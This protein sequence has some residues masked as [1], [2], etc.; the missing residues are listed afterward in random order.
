MRGRTERHLEQLIAG[1]P[2]GPATALA[3]GARALATAEEPQL[4]PEF[5]WRDYTIFLLSI[6]AQI[7]HSLMVQYLY[8]AYSLG[9]PQTPEDQ[10]EKVAAWR[11]VILGIAKE[12][13]GHLATVQNAL[14]LMDAPLELDRE[15][16][17]W[18]SRLAP[19]PFTLERLSRASLA[20]Y[21]VAESPK[22]WPPDV[23]AGERKEIEDL[24]SGYGGS[25]VNRVGELYSDLIKIIRNPKLLPGAVFHPDTYPLQAS[26]D[27][28]GRGYGK[29]ARGS[30]V[31]GTTATPD[32][33]VLRMASRTDAVAALQAVAEQGEAPGKASAADAESSHFRRFLNVFRAFPKDGSWQ[34]VLPLP[35]NPLAPGLAAGAGQTPITNSEAG[36]WANI[37]NV[38]YRMLLSYLAHTY[39]APRA[40]G[41][42]GME[43]HRG[44]I[45]N[46]MFGEMYNLRA[47][48]S[49]LVQFPLAEGS[50]ER[51]GPTFQMPY[52]LQLPESEAAYWTLHLNLIAATADLLV[53]A[54]AVG[55]G[56]RIEYAKALASLDATAAREMALYADA[57]RVRIGA[58]RHDEDDLMSILEIRILPPLAIARLGSSS[59]PLENYDLVVEDPLG[60]RTDPAVRDAPGR[61]R[62]RRDRRGLYAARNPLPRRRAHSPRRAVPRSLRAHERRCPRASDEGPLEGRRARAQG[63]P[64]DRHARQHQSLPAHRRRQ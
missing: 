46:R 47:I 59:E 40:A 60:H 39:N 2:A 53:Q 5:T 50:S 45:I 22:T 51:C 28:W 26:W 18:D 58:H 19:Y 52:T 9:G 16:Y 55:S 1:A 4:P 7:E 12:E 33:L 3:A 62:H 42:A 57:D 30:S 35:T 61:S 27:E 15:D 25:Q 14:K 31:A 13:M 10:R 56:E 20:K 24:A 17:P 64:L 32:V 49:I 44:V 23:S 54:R 29:G 11:Q 8:A 37:F 43:S 21:I 38:R 63:P 34:P 6:A 48:A 36:I 41:A